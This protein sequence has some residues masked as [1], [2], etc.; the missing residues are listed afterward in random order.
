MQLSIPVTV[1][2]RDAE[3]PLICKFF[4]GETDTCVMATRL[5]PGDQKDIWVAPADGIQITHVKI[6]LEGLEK[7]ETIFDNRSEAQRT[8]TGLS[9]N[10]VSGQV[11]A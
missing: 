11:T 2:N 1:I 5:E 4:D 8:G 6:D 3:R 10:T 7:P 9:D